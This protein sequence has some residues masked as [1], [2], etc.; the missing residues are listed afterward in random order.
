[1]AII[2]LIDKINNAVEKRETS[3]ALY[4]D[5]PKDFDTFDHNMLLY[6]WEHYDFRG[7]VLD[8]FKSYLCIRTQY[9][10]Y[11]NC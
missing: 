3:F 1:M 5:L 7:I 8:W 6:K 10:Y 2:E 9:V 11:N 4:L